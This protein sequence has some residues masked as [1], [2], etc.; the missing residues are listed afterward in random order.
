MTR[1]F[2]NDGYEDRYGESSDSGSGNSSSSSSSEEDSSDEYDDEMFT[3]FLHGR[4]SQDKS[5]EMLTVTTNNNATAKLNGMLSIPQ[6]TSHAHLFNQVHS[7]RSASFAV[8]HENLPGALRRAQKLST[9]S[10]RNANAI[11]VNPST[12]IATIPNSLSPN[13]NR[14]SSRPTINAPSGTAAAAPTLQLLS[15]LMAPTA[16]TGKLVP[17]Y[18]PPLQQPF[19]QL[20]LPQVPQIQRGDSFSVDQ[21]QQKIYT[22]TRPSVSVSNSSLIAAPGTAILSRSSTVSPSA[23]AT[24]TNQVTVQQQPVFAVNSGTSVGPSSR[25]INQTHLQPLIKRGSIIASNLMIAP[26]IATAANTT[27]ANNVAAIAAFQHPQ[28]EK[29]EPSSITSKFL[30]TATSTKNLSANSSSS[31]AAAALSSFRG[32]AISLFSPATTA[33]ATNFISGIRSPASNSKLL[34]TTSLSNMADMS[35]S[36]T[37]LGMVLMR[38]D[39][40]TDSGVLATSG[41]EITSFSMAD[42]PGAFIDDIK[43]DAGSGDDEGGGGGNWNGGITSKNGLLSSTTAIEDKKKPPEAT[44][45]VGAKFEFRQKEIFS[46]LSLIF[47]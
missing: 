33:A 40:A 27:S 32:S 4:N 42:L 16:A 15:P 22:H 39:G 26:T 20:L 8:N 10:P 24:T 44:G 17:Q 36:L 11:P 47:G 13:S 19:Q 37:S 30:T 18:L 14:L 25:F 46:Q 41:G 9:T 35:A 28:H 21:Q 7:A 6:S 3:R 23:P 31:A 38:H 12:A 5:S 43:Y 34:S 29:L 1:K 45:I 2:K